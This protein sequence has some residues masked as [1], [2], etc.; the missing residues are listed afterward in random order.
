MVI[1]GAGTDTITLGAPNAG[2]ETIVYRFTSDGNV[3]GGADGSD[4]VDGFEYGVD[5]L[6]LVDVSDSSP[7]VDLAAFDDDTD[8]PRISVFTGD[9]VLTVDALQI[10]FGEGG[11]VLTINFVGNLPI[12]DSTDGT[13]RSIHEHVTQDGAIVRRYE[14]NDGSSLANVLGGDDF[15]EVGDVSQLPE[16]L[17][18]L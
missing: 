4:T 18:I 2:A 1:G 3:W 5:E 8:R 11:A 10:T 12:I 15:V 14:L 9:G 6:V 7:I 17:D 13:G 16:G